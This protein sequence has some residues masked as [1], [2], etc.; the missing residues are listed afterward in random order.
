[1]NNRYMKNRFR[2]FVLALCVGGISVV[3][4]S[5]IDEQ[6]GPQ[7]LKRFFG[8][9]VAN[10]TELW[11]EGQQQEQDGALR[12]AS[13]TYKKVYTK[14][15]NSL[16]APGAVRAQADI[17]FAQKKW[18][19][20]FDL[21]Q[22]GIDNYAN[23]IEDYNAFLH[24]QY[25]A[26]VEIMEHRRLPFLFGGFSSPELAIP[27]FEKIISN[28]PQWGRA[29]EALMRVG[30]AHQQAGEYEA[31]ITAYS[32]LEFSHPKSSRA[33]QALWQHIRALEK[34]SEKF[35]NNVKFIDRLV[36]ATS[37]F[38]NTYA[39]EERKATLITLRNSLYEKK[40]RMKWNEVLF[41]EEVVKNQEAAR[42]SCE[43][44]L[45]RYPKSQL[46]EEAQER[47]KQYPVASKEEV[48]GGEVR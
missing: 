24:G 8:N 7:S 6:K 9:E 46:A 4:A 26:A 11:L 43:Q 13:K 12:S 44:L 10:A 39:D 36:T 37:R 42:L 5:Y 18:Q 17:L 34:L 35:P 30:D 32:T 29:P 41:Y 19:E 45:A 48:L 27:L 20:A 38:L 47:L 1:M 21:Y 28:G 25:E 22:Y 2:M 16:E 31:A 23:R 40:A 15:P 14:W 3:D 33:Q